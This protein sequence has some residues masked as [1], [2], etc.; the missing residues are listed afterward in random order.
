MLVYGL[1]SKELKIKFT[2]ANTNA[3]PNK[4]LMPVAIAPKIKLKNTEIII[5][6]II[7]NNN[8]PM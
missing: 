2:K 8:I 1:I 7:A 4:I 6:A 3:E 5:I